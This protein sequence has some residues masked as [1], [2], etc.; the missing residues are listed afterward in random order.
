M[1]T[2]GAPEVARLLK[3][4]ASPAIVEQR[5]RTL[6][7]I[8]VRPGERGLDLGCGPGFL[9]VELARAVGA[10]G[11]VTALDASPEMREAARTR[12]AEAGLVSRVELV[13]GDAVQ[14]EFPAG[15]FDFA[16]AVQ[17]YLYVPE[18]ARAL[19]EAWRVL[20]PGGRLVVVDTDWDSCLWW[21]SDRARHRR[22]MEARLAQFVNPH[23]PPALPALLRGACFRLD[24]A[25]VI[26]LLELDYARDSFSG[27]LIPVMADLAVRHG[28]PRQE[29][30]AWKADL[31]G[32]TAPGQYFFSVNRYLFRA[33]KPAT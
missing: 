10:G 3:V 21:T 29:A 28:V 14:L 1:A 30:E 25:E 24:H 8:D 23:L 18:V 9:T 15:T 12:L 2:F 27:D 20:R 31:L 33:T 7:A 19:G 6:A 22:V 16:A 5:A 4:Y 11:R 32:R 13:G 17:V 26:P